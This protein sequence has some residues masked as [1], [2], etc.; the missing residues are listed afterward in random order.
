M[1]DKW[2]LPLRHLLIRRDIGD[3]LSLRF[4]LRLT[5]SPPSSYSSLS[6][7]RPVLPHHPTPTPLPFPLLFRPCIL[8]YLYCYIML[9]RGLRL[10]V[11]RAGLPV[12][13][14]DSLNL[15]FQIYRSPARFLLPS[16]PSSVRGSPLSLLRLVPICT[17]FFW[18]CV[19]RTDAVAACKRHPLST[20][21]M[22]RVRGEKIAA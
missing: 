5:D 22:S 9:A 20:E 13:V 17:I 6:F 15:L 2:L 11:A 12:V 21:V 10:A 3:T 4:I 14:P 7:T 16:S 19:L 8:S 1:G 18:R